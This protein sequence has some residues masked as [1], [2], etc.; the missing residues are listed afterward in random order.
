MLL[1]FLGLGFK[2]NNTVIALD[3]VADYYGEKQAFYFAWLLHYTSWL[4]IPSVVGFII[5]FI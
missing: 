1:G 5:Y 2:R 4:M 3:Y